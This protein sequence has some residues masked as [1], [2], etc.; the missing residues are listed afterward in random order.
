[1]RFV[2]IFPEAENIHLIKDVGMIP[3]IMNKEYGFKSKIVCYK[4][5]S[6][7]YK[8]N[9]FKNIELEFIKKISGNKLI[10]QI[11]YL[12]KNSRKIDILNLIH[13]TQINLILINIYKAI[14]RKGKVYL[15]MDAN[16]NI[17]NTVNPSLNTIKG[18]IK[19]K[20][21]QKCELISVE[22]EE[23]HKYLVQNWK[24]NVEY[25]PN[26]FY[27]FQSI[28]EF[29]SDNKENIILT[30]GRIGTY[31]KANEILLEGFKLASSKINN[32]SLRIVGPI[33][34]HFKEYIT[35]FFSENPRLKDKITFLGP[36]YDLEKLEM[37]YKRAKIFCLTSRS[38]GFPLVF[39]EAIKNGC[40][41]ITSNVLSA[42]DITNYGKLGS[43]FTIDN[44]LEL[45]HKFIEVCNDNII[46]NLHGDI[47]NYAYNNF[48]WSSICKKI[49]K[50][51]I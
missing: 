46:D 17:K 5:G 6:Y 10:D 8:E 14:N 37:E 31:E 50:K 24:I 39:L 3:Y 1:M 28:N 36:I 13:V 32:W 27:N 33:E 2:T 15:K 49:H 51:L 40:Y 9:E 44:S 25:I 45:S 4:N 12:L 47:I 34:E 30:V 41:V 22:T 26:G 42:Y 20:T 16:I 29:K 23:L 35:N 48:E 18:I 7:P 11:I 38:E 43:I 21:I 19:R